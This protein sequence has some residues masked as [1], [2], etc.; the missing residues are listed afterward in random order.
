MHK[1][2]MSD[3]LYLSAECIT[4]YKKISAR[5]C[6]SAPEIFDG[7]LLQLSARAQFSINWHRHLGVHWNYDMNCQVCRGIFACRKRIEQFGLKWIVWHFGKYMYFLCRWKHRY[8]SL[9][10]TVNMQLQV[11][12]IEEDTGNKMDKIHQVDLTT[13]G[14]SEASWFSLFH[15]LLAVVSHLHCTNMRVLAKKNKIKLAHFPKC[16]IIPKRCSVKMFISTAIW[17]CLALGDD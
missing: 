7:I 5:V 12:A 3:P 13:F 2:S 9:V 10:F 11:A 1:N 6:I 8:H 14:Q 4:D 16:W 17:K 15:V